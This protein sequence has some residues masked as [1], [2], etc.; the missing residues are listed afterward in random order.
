MGG[1]LSGGA[2]FPANIHSDVEVV[3]KFR[4]NPLW[5]IAVDGS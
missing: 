5:F 4:A 3:A 1:H 2:L